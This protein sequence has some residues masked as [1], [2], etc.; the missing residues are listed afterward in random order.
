MGDGAS[1]DTL[2]R[3][4]IGVDLYFFWSTPAFQVEFTLVL[5]H[6]NKF[7]SKLGVLQKKRPSSILFAA[8]FVSYPAQVVIELEF[9]VILPLLTGTNV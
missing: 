5:L 1:P 6:I 4:I 9:V 8:P 2:R 7:H 3:G